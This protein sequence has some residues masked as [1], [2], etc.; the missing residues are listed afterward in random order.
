MGLERLR[1]TIGERLATAR[2][3]RAVARRLA[4]LDPATT[5]R[6]EIDEWA[7]EHGDR[8]ALAA[9][10]GSERASFA[11]LAGR[12]HSWAR[13]AILHGAAPSEPVALLVAN[14]PE[15]VA[16]WLGLA[17]AGVTA[18]VIDQGLDGPALA[19]TFARLTPRRIVVDAALLPRFET[20][21][22]HLALTAAVWV[23]GPHAMAYPRLDEA[24][25]DLSPERLRPAD[26]RTV[27][28]STPAVGFADAAGTVVLD[29]AGALRALHAAA[30]A[31]RLGVE[32]R[33]FVAPATGLSAVLAPGIGLA[34]GALGLLG[35][36]ATA[37]AEALARHRPTVLALGPG[38]APPTA[39]PRR[40][41]GLGPATAGPCD[42]VWDGNGLATADG[43][44]LWSATPPS[45]R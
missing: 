10:D 21:T 12:A 17:E 25:D 37:L 3:S 7:A 22:P 31:L 28:A 42:L 13:W 27:T 34:A 40:I 6:D 14:R 19:A 26:R 16:A 1:R 20:A 8:L 30:A 9:T 41:L 24:L 38:D 32:D 2:L 35:A 39:P 23:H 45:A 11:T 5:L 43:D 33:L 4:R 15:R 44:L 36:D 29:H 18:M